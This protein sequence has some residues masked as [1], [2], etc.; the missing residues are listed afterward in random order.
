MLTE[1]PQ[2]IGLQHW[3]NISA[4]NELLICFPCTFIFALK[5]LNT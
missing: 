4:L 1:L 5:Q 2:G 3:W